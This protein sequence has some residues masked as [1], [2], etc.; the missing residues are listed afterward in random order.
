MG[1]L[2]AHG[3]DGYGVCFN[4]THWNIIRNDVVIVILSFLNDKIGIV[5]INYTDI[6]LIPKGQNLQKVI[7]Y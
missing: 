6:V 7:E 5:D 1:P 2:K 3:P 4:Q